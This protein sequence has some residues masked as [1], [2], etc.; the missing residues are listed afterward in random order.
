MNPKALKDLGSV[1]LNIPFKCKE[2]FFN[3]Q[4]VDYELWHEDQL[5]VLFKNKG[6]KNDPNKFRGINIL[7]VASKL[8]SIIT[9]SRL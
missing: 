7:S 2:D 1:C 6:S 9:N 8:V 4:E 3:N 5:K